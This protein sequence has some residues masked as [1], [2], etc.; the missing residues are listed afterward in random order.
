MRYTATLTTITG[1][2]FDRNIGNNIQ[3]II[4]WGKNRKDLHF[5]T[6]DEYYL[7]IYLVDESNLKD[8]EKINPI[9]KYIRAEMGD[10]L[11]QYLVTDE[12]FKSVKQGI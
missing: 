11:K 1:G 12:T 7:N 2:V 6:Y 4:K 3:E 9:T 5:H 8:Y 10:K